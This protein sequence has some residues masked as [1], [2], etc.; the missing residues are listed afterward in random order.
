MTAIDGV[1]EDF[2][3]E[4]HLIT[5]SLIN[6]RYKWYCIEEKIINWWLI[7]NYMPGITNYEDMC[8]NMNLSDKNG[9]ST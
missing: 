5:Y 4:F 3:K 6:I 8:S 7:N 2:G 9:S 1:L